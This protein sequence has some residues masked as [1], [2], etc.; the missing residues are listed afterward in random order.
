MPTT[1][2]TTHLHQKYEHEPPTP[3]TN[4]HGLPAANAGS[5]ARTRANATTYQ[6]LPA[7]K[8]P[9]VTL[10]TRKSAQETFDNVSYFYIYINSDFYTSLL[11]KFLVIN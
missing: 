9:K 4:H 5:Q 11:T 3:R 1:P 8:I 2:F 10:G 7:S 6:Y